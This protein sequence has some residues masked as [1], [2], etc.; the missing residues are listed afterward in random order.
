MILNFLN[1]S[2]YLLEYGVPFTNVTELTE[3]LPSGKIRQQI[4]PVMGIPD[5]E[6]FFILRNVFLDMLIAEINKMNEELGN[7]GKIEIMYNCNVTGIEKRDEGALSVSMENRLINYSGSMNADII[8]GC[9][10]INSGNHHFLS[11]TLPEFTS[12]LSLLF[13]EIL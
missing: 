9:D 1:I 8:F 5:I 2:H 13:G 12:S 10:G 4:I 3:I 11:F 6:R 7:D